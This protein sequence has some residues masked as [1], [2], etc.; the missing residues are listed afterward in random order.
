MLLLSHGASGV[1]E[2]LEPGRELGWNMGGTPGA[3]V[4]YALAFVSV[5]IFAIGLRRRILFWKLGKPREEGFAD[6]GRRIWILVR[7][8]LLQV[9]TRRRLLPGLFHSLIFYSFLVLFVTTLIVMAQMDFGLEIFRGQF[10]LIVSLLAD[11]AGGLLLIGVV[12]AAVR[13][14][15]QKPDFLPQTKPVD[16]LV[17]SLLAFLVLTG[18]IAEGAR[19]RFHPAGDPWSRWTPIGSLFGGLLGGAGAETG[20][21]VHGVIWWLHALGTFTMIALIPYTKFLHMLSIPTNQLLSKNL[22]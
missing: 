18:F 4:M 8:A 5:A 19:I 6:W 3:I 2:L 16:T 20:R 15:M 12:I 11:L 10:Y 13:R 1:N 9:Q 22:V 21:A 14:Y 17:L 7:E